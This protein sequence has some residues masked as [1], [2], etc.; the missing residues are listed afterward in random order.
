MEQTKPLR[1]K[2]ETN[3]KLGNYK[4]KRKLLNRSDAIDDSIDKAEKYEQIINDL[5]Q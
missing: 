5:K 1:I 3:E 4:K 2:P